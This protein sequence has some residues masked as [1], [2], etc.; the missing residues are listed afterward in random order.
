MALSGSI[1]TGVWTDPDYGNTWKV[2][3]NWTATQNVE[4]NTSTIS[5]ITIIRVCPNTG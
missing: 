2:V 3:L 5:C 1:S 4:N